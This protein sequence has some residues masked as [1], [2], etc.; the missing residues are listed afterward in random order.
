MGCA[1]FMSVFFIA[2][3]VFC[4]VKN[5]NLNVTNA[6]PVFFGDLSTESNHANSL[7]SQSPIVQ[8]ENA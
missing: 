1:I 8:Y 3:T 5:T 4:A 6:E 7:S 2:A